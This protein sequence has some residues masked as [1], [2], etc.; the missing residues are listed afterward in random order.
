MNTAIVL[1]GIGTVTALNTA[2]V[3]VPSR[4]RTVPATGLVPRSSCTEDVVSVVAATGSLKT[5]TM[6]AF[7]VTSR[8]PG[9]GQVRTTTGR[10]IRGTP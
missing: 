10:R 8:L 6:V 7:R 9:A 1:T 5:M 2:T 4:T 3:P